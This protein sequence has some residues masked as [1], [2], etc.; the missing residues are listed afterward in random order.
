MAACLNNGLWCAALLDGS[1]QLHVGLRR[2]STPCVATEWRHELFK[3]A[4]NI[5]LQYIRLELFL[6][7]DTSH[8]KKWFIFWTIIHSILW[9]TIGSVSSCP[10][11][12]EAQTQVKKKKGVRCFKL[13]LIFSTKFTKGV[14]WPSFGKNYNSDLVWFLMVC[15]SMIIWSHCFLS[16]WTS[17]I[18]RSYKRAVTDKHESKWNNIKMTSTEI[19]LDGNVL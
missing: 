16:S 17:N 11:T 8:K 1:M 15:Q 10:K 2:G 7:Y 4:P 14:L 12:P 6:N 19:T 9:Q 3:H 5:K 13:F 18:Y